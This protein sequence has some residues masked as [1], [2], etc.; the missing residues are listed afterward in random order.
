MPALDLGLVR[1]DLESTPSNTMINLMIAVLTLF[2]FALLLVALLVLLRRLRQ[3]QQMRAN[4]LPQ[5]G[6]IDSMQQH[7]HQRS[8]NHRRLTITTGDDRSSRVVVIRP[9]GSP[10]L[11]NPNRPPHSP[12]NIPQI[13]IT[14][15]DEHDDKGNKRASGRVVVVRVGDKSV[16]MEPLRE[17]PSP[18]E[19]LP[20]YNEKEPNDGF[21]ALDLDRIGGLKEKERI[22]FK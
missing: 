21:F 1:R 13:H 18:S 14:F 6:G 2:F 10:M 22:N 20:A 8:R 12:D 11:I 17:A 5:Y 3:Q 15:P 7:G 4:T 9:D 16:G 19:Q